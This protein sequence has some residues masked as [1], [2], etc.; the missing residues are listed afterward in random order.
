MKGLRIGPFW[1][2]IIVIAAAYL[3]FDNAFPPIMPTT[4]MITYMII[5]VLGVVVYYA[6]AE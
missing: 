1:R 3:V 2:A 6:Y 4:L 5:T